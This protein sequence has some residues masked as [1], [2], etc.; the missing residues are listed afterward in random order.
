MNL[1]NLKIFDPN[2]K[3][4]NDFQY[5][6]FNL[7]IEKSNNQNQNQNQSQSQSQKQLESQNSISD[8]NNIIESIINDFKEIDQNTMKI[9]YNDIVYRNNVYNYLPKLIIHLY[10]NDHFIDYVFSALY[11]YIYYYRA[12]KIQSNNKSYIRFC[13]FI[14]KYINYLY[15][16]QNYDLNIII[17]LINYGFKNSVPYHQYISYE[18]IFRFCHYD[19]ASRIIIEHKQFFIDIFCHDIE[20]SNSL[21]RLFEILDEIE[22]DG[23]DNW[24]LIELLLNEKIIFNFPSQITINI[25]DSETL[26]QLLEYLYN[27][28][29]FNV[30]IDIDIFIDYIFCSPHFISLFNTTHLHS[31]IDDYIYHLLDK[32]SPTILQ[33]IKHK[34]FRLYHLKYYLELDN[35]DD[36][37]EQYLYE[38]YKYMTD[39]IFIEIVKNK[40]FTEYELISIGANDEKYEY[41]FKFVNCIKYSSYDFIEIGMIRKY[42]GFDLV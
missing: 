37:V 21:S 41:K 1:S 30:N 32:K 16:Y 31:I 29:S 15:L 8:N 11:D 39:H 38:S 10:N 36:Y 24:K 26:Y 5:N 12:L 35:Y 23:G 13:Q 42:F 28:K 34:L 4:Y 19:I 18:D 20:D 17:E 7:L 2:M 25:T 40:L 3:L 14:P 27:E 6:V 22:L 33:L 9:Y